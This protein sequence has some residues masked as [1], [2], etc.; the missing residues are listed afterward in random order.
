MHSEDA[1][2]THG[3]VATN[4]E[5][6][7]RLGL[8]SAPPAAEAISIARDI[9]LVRETGGHVHFR[10]VTTL[11]GLDLIRAAKKEK[12]PVTCGITPA[13]LLLSDIAIEGRNH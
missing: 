7:T 2:L 9:A 6:A 1:G 10:Q 12:L 5:T 3:A 11:D 8:A 4:S 13:H